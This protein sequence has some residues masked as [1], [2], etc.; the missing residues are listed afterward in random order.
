MCPFFLSSSA[1]TSGCQICPTLFCPIVS[2]Q[3]SNGFLQSILSPQA[4]VII[5]SQLG[6]LLPKKN[7][8]VQ[9]AACAVTS[10]CHRQGPDLADFVLPNCFR[11][12]SHQQ[13]EADGPPS[14]PPTC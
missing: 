6:D 14:Y 9:I 13:S 11:T 4:I 1:V 2:E 10:G 8:C 3:S 5:I 12:I 7:K